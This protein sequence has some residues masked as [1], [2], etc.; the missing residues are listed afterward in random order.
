MVSEPYSSPKGFGGSRESFQSANGFLL[1]LMVPLS[2]L[3]NCLIRQGK[4]SGTSR[5]MVYK[6]ALP[7]RS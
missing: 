5:N 2:E 1:A 6:N 7:F 4:A 3:L